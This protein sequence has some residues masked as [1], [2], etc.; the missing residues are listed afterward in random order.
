MRYEEIAGILLREARQAGL[1]TYNMHSTLDTASLSRL[2][3]VYCVPQDWPQPSALWAE[4]SFEWDCLQT[5]RTTTRREEICAL[6]HDADE[7]CLHSRRDAYGSISLD[8]IFILPHSWL[9]RVAV[10]PDLATLAQELRALAQEA[11]LDSELENPS[12]IVLPDRQEELRVIGGEMPCFWM[13][14]EKILDQPLLLEQELQ[15]ILGQIQRLLLGL[16]ERFL[17]VMRA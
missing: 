5:V 16:G 12:F 2:F 6:Y 10:G 4:L 9:E 14:E 11:N 1:R 7:D 15:S 3:S 8:V 17:E 13:L